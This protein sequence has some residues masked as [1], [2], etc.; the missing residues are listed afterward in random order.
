MTEQD[1]MD[2]AAGLHIRQTHFALGRIDAAQRCVHARQGHAKSLRTQ[3]RKHA[4][5]GTPLTGKTVKSSTRLIESKPEGS[6]MR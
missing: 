3:Q 4:C 2:P 6:E 1:V 5:G